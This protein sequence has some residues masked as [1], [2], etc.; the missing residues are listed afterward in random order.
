MNSKKSLNDFIKE[1]A[2]KYQLDAVGFTRSERIKE[3]FR[4]QKIWKDQWIPDRRFHNPEL[5]Y[6]WAKSIVIGI[7]SYF[8]KTDIVKNNRFGKIARYTTGD[9]Y[10]LLRKKLSCIAK[11]LKKIKNIKTSKVFTNGPFDEKEYAYRA[12]LGFKG[13]NGLLINKDFGS[14]FL[15]GMFFTDTEFFYSDTCENLCS[16]CKKCEINCPT[17]ALKD[18]IIDRKKCLQE[19][20]QWAVSVPLEIKKVWSDRFYGC[21]SCQDPCPF[22]ED[23]PYTKNEPLRGRLGYQIDMKKLLSEEADNIKNK[24]KGNQIGANWIKVEA[25][26]KNAFIVLGNNNFD[27]GDDLIRKYIQHPDLSVQDSLLW[28]IKKIRG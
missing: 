3:N 20:T 18:G 14:F 9:Y 21:D 10:H 24:F 12:G 26:I 6:P 8:N 1:L 2:A 22:N 19:L 23:L 25:L 4:M 28:Y 16:N 15:I 5:M 17:E 27:V 11:E 13:R 7:I